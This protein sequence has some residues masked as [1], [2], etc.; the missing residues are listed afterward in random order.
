MLGFIISLPAHA[1]EIHLKNF[2]GGDLADGGVCNFGNWAVSQTLSGR[3]TIQNTA[4]AGDLILDDN[5]RVRLTGLNADEFNI[6]EYEQPGSPIAPGDNTTFIVW[7]RPKSPGLKIANL[8]IQNNDGDEDPY[9]VTLNGTGINTPPTISNIPNQVTSEDSPLPTITFMIGDAE[10]SPYNLAVWATSTNQQVVPDRN[11]VLDEFGAERTLTITPLPNQFGS[12]RVIVYVGDGFEYTFDDFWLHVVE[13]N[14]PPTIT[15]TPDQVTDEDTPT[16]PIPFTVDDVE[17]DPGDLTVTGSS[18]NTDLVPDENIVFG[19]PMMSKAQVLNAAGDHTVTVTPAANQSGTATI[20]I[21]VSDGVNQT[22]D[23]FVLT[24]N[25]VNDPPQ[26]LLPLPPITLVQGDHYALALSDLYLFVEDVDDPDSTLTWSPVDTMMDV[27]RYN[28]VVTADSIL[29][30]APTDWFGVD[31][32]AVIVS[33]GELSDT[34]DIIVTV[35]Q[36]ETISAVG[37]R[38]GVPETYELSPN[39]PNPFNPTT[40]IAYGLPDRSHVTVTI[41]NT[42]GQIIQV[43]VDETKGAGYHTIQWDASRVGSG[44]YFYQIRAGDFTMVRKCTLMK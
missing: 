18:G 26:F 24:V 20:T 34:T 11:L 36:G 28:L 3:I 29:L 8:T 15:D 27:M 2:W 43:L 9:N 25:A 19:T 32:I 5:P 1:Q 7:F 42:K 14:D 35:T 40:T 10:Q 33:D 21:T 39:Y 22:S 17:T 6:K 16:P 12:F 23:T 37:T 13:V 31:T 38:V 30:D 44:I 4:G 41:Y